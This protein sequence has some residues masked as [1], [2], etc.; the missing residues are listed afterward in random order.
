M[1]DTTQ[2]RKL[3]DQTSTEIELLKAAARATE[4]A[5]RPM[6]PHRDN[7]LSE[8]V[9]TAHAI[10]R[11]IRSRTD[12]LRQEVGQAIEGARDSR[13]LAAL[14]AI[15]PR[16]IEVLGP[17]DEAAVRLAFTIADGRDPKKVA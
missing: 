5:T 13:D 6:L 11:A 2:A 17:Q 10:D 12:A 3:F 9:N 1:L 8:A 14:I 4:A 15:L 7:D 16:V